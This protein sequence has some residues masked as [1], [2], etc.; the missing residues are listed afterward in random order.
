MANQDRGEV[1]F[2]AAGETWTLHF[3]VDAICHVEDAVGRSFT[4][5]A[6]DMQNKP[7]SVGMKT[8]RALMWGGLRDR[9]PDITLVAA[10]E[11]IPHIGGM[12]GAIEKIGEAFKRAFPETKG[13]RPP[14]A[15][16]EA[17]APAAAD[18]TGQT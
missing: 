12:V 14:Q 13:T 6:I 10:G 1:S 2:D 5:I 7:D 3:S 11:L 18:T 16:P 8:V 15:E 9:H 17:E 4:A